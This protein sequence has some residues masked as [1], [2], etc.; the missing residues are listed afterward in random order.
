MDVKIVEGCQ[1]LGRQQEEDLEITN[2]PHPGQE[3]MVVTTADSRDILPEV[4]H[5]G[6]HKILE[7]HHREIH[8]KAGQDLGL[9]DSKVKVT[10]RLVEDH[11]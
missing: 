5:G 6:R 8:G 3:A 9:I 10:R 4:A 2:N 1:Y 11:R 7:V